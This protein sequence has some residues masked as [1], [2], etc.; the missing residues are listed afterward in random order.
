VRGR[1]ST[2]L[3]VLNKETQHRLVRFPAKSSYQRRQG[4]LQIMLKLSHPKNFN[5]LNYLGIF[6]V[7]L[8][9]AVSIVA[10]ISIFSN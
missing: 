10:A 3:T 6:A 1:R 4:R 7:V 9:T 8:V 5:F 2:L